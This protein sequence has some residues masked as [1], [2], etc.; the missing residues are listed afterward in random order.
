MIRS[1]KLRFDPVEDRLLL[2]LTSHD[3]NSE[4]EHRFHVTRRLCARW[5]EDLR[6]M[7]DIYQGAPAVKPVD[8]RAR[9]GAD[10]QPASPRPD[11][12][13][14]ASG[15]AGV[16]EHMAGAPSVPTLLTSIRCGRRRSDGRWVIRFAA[17]SDPAQSLVLTDETLV[18]IIDALGQQLK[19]SGWGLV[20]VTERIP[21][22][23]PAHPSQLH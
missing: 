18:A 11:V 5:C 15:S 7:L 23:S 21:V 14:S 20:P 1:I 4:L 6:T 19:S 3:G 13:A 9:K 22:R 2:R 12:A 10:T 17:G 16:P 8:R